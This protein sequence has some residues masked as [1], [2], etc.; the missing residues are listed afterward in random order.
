MSP[1]KIIFNTV[2]TAE[3]NLRARWNQQTANFQPVEEKKLLE[4]IKELGAG[5]DRVKCVV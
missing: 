5:S 3:P 4:D 2:K 1:I